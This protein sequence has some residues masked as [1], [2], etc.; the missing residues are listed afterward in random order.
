MK[1]I[2]LLLLCFTA[3]T[4]IAQIEF[5]GVVKDTL[6]KPVELAN[7]VALNKATNALES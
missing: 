3:Q 7:V 1:N 5:E 2:L 6:G 4:T